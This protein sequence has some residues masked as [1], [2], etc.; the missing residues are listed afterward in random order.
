MPA[1]AEALGHHPDRAA[2]ALAAVL[3]TQDGNS[4]MVRILEQIAT[5]A[6]IEVIGEAMAAETGEVLDLVLELA[7]CAATHA[8]AYAHVTDTPIDEVWDEIQTGL[9]E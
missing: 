7:D 8:Q 4:Y 5:P 2:S 1:L 9:H 3:R 6:C